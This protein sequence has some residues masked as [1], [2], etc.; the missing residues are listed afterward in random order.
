MI[1]KENRIAW[2]W[3]SRN[4]DRRTPDWTDGPRMIELL[5]GAS[6]GLEVEFCNTVRKIKRNDERKIE[7][8]NILGN[9]AEQWSVKDIR[10]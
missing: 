2:G 3:Y 5:S 6:G 4:D 10:K 9:T 1:S 7:K 8:L